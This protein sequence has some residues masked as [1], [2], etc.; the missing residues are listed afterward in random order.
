MIK[1]VKPSAPLLALV[2]L[3]ASCTGRPD[4]EER[5][6]TSTPAVETH[7]STTP[8]VVADL[9]EEA[10]PVPEP[11]PWAEVKGV[12]TDRPRSSP[13]L[14]GKPYRFQLYTHCRIDFRVDF[15]GSFWQAY[16]RY[17]RPD[18]PFQHGR[19]T[20]VS[21]QVAIFEANRR[22]VH[23]YFVRN[24]TPKPALGCR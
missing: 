22:E 18:D 2:A 7:T 9:P 10:L 19:M 21:P 13:A 8:P 14:P 15:D 23:I 17:G 3:L 6:P 16:R 5:Y 24:D 4:V 11:S 1:G 20:L 12:E